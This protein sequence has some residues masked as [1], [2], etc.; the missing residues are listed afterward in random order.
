MF[1]CLAPFF[2]LT[3]FFR[4]VRSAGSL[5]E[6]LKDRSSRWN[7]KASSHVID[8]IRAA[9]LRAYTKRSAVWP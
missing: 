6:S 2:D 1:K 9:P 5:L 7:D 8:G 3:D 4:S